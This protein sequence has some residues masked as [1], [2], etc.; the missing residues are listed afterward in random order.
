MNIYIF[1]E[2][3]P[4]PYKPYFD[5]EFAYYI[6]NGNNLKIFVATQ[7]TS[8]IHPRVI[9]YGLDKLTYLFPTTIS[10]LPKFIGPI[11]CRIIKSPL[12]SFN[13]MISIYDKA[14]SIKKNVMRF[15]RTMVL[16]ESAPD[17]CYIHN[18]V[19]AD[20]IDFLHI[21]YPQSR[22]VMYYHG[23]EVGGVKRVVR[24]SQLFKQMDVVFSNTNFSKDQ[25][26]GRGCPSERVVV[27]PVGFDLEDYPLSS[28][29][30]YRERGVLRLISIGRLSKEKGLDFSIKAVAELVS[31]G[32]KNIHYTIVGRG[33][34][35][36]HLK[37]LVH[38]LGLEQYVT[39][40]GELDKPDVVSC[41]Q[42]S[43]ILILP[44][45]VTD[46]GA[47]TQAT[48]VQE[49]MLMQLLVVVTEA[50]GVP[51]STADAL[52]K[53]SVPICDSE[54]ISKKIIEIMKLNDTEMTDLGDKGRDFAIK[55]FNINTTGKKLLEQAIGKKSS[56][57]L[58]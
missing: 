5:T 32:I 52:R 55:N 4:N 9:Y 41:L 2:N 19:T 1:A 50:G 27:V 54:A 31:Q 34:E 23:G 56:N 44:S 45:I 3:Y 16:P 30:L 58:K 53:F 10:T 14:L 40:T 38:S 15:T 17:L 36:T 35:E 13:I 8:I 37:E 6:R 7:F 49:A 43:D 21:L 20:Y 57:R 47:E 12:K 18:I 29:K 42:Q 51:E 33:M 25:V 26:I 22:L 11:I 28:P 24:D 48:V 46:T 39:F